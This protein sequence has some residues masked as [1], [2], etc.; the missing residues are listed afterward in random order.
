MCHKINF[1]KLFL[2]VNQHP[3]LNHTKIETHSVS[4]TNT[5]IV[6]LHVCAV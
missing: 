5:S 6:S 2:R 1:K 3:D 4:Y